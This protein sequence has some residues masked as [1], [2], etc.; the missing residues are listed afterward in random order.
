[1]LHD[2]RLFVLAK[3]AVREFRTATLTPTRQA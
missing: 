3:I 2:T 1:L